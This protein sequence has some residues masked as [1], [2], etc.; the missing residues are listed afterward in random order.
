LALRVA[1]INLARGYR[2]GERQTELL[3][4]GLAGSGIRQVLIARRDSPLIDRLADVDVGIRGCSGDLPGAFAA[5]RGADIAHSH[6]GRGVY[7]AWLRSLMSGTPF[8]VTRRVN[9]PIRRRALTRAAYRR[10]AFVVSI[11]D[12]VADVVRAYD[13]RIRSR[14]I[15][16]SSS[17]L[18][19]DAASVRAIRERFPGKWL[20]GNVAALD[21]EQK[22]QEFIVAVARGVRDSHPNMQFLLVGD[23]RDAQ[24]LRE[25]AADLPN[26]TF[27]GFVDNVG[28]WLAAL[29]L[30]V[31]PSNKEGM[32]SILLDAMERELPIVASRAGGI[33]S[34]VKDG[35]T[36][37]LID[38]R[39]PD[40]LQSAILQLYADEELRRALGARG[41]AFAAAFRPEIMS[42]K[43]R[44]LYDEVM[45]PRGG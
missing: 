28:D 6:E 13:E 5:L 11:S 2:G 9:N 27:V 16:S 17:G 41:R 29:D 25:L 4:R 12:E 33:P 37:M 31:F 44:A 19:A 32:G 36:G 22:G 35:D 1:H 40:Q 8:V 34:V 21:N 18:E 39:R 20:I 14:V 42:A 3:I 43:Y 23:G 10:A 30:F 26:V 45:L 38:V 15:H 24:M 7:A